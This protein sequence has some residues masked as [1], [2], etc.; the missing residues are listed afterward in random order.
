MQKITPFLWFI[1]HAEEAMKFYVEVFKNSKIVEITRY[2][3]N[4]EGPM[5]GMEGKVLNGIFELNG[6][7]FMAIDGGPNVFEFTGA[8][9]FIVD[10][11]DQ[12]E[13]DYYWE[14]LS[15]DPKSEQ[16]GWCKDKYGIY[17]QIIPKQMGEFMTDPDP[18]KVARVTHAMLQMK[19]IDVNELQKAY[20]G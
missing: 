16:C 4:A 15:S 2:P 7:R 13:V 10:C 1:D 9:S 3:E 6:Q 19:K 20:K 18:A 12:T 14:K 8:I 11:E 17:W 5:K